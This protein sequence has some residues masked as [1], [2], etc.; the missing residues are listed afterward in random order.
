MRARRFEPV[1]F[2]SQQPEEF[3]ADLRRGPG[4]PAGGA[5]VERQRLRMVGLR[6]RPSA[7]P[8]C[9]EGSDCAALGPPGE[10]AHH[11]LA[12]VLGP[13]SFGSEAWGTACTTRRR[14]S[15]PRRSGDNRGC[16]S[17][18]RTTPRQSAGSWS[19]T[20]SCAPLGERQPRGTS[21]ARMRWTRRRRARRVAR[22]CASFIAS[23]LGCACGTEP[24]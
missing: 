23:T 1:D 13:P 17:R 8:I 18:W 14:R 11:H 24:C 10:N 21:P 9:S 22:R 20:A 2:L 15:V 5:D 3:L 6:R 7:T 4:T 16:A 19:S 12:A